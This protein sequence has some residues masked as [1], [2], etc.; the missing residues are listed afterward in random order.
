MLSTIKEFV[1]RHVVLTGMVVIL[2]CGFAYA[3]LTSHT[4]ALL[5]TLLLNLDAD[6]DGSIADETWLVT[7][8]DVGNADTSIVREGAGD[9][10]VEGNHIYRAGGTDVADGDV[11]DDITITNISQV[12][13]ISASAAE[14]NTPLDGASV[15]LTEFME[16]ETIGDTIIS[17]DQ[18]TGLGGATAA[19]MSLWNDADAPA[20]LVSLGVNAT[21]AE[22]DT[23]LDGASVTLTEFRELETIGDVTISA[24]QWAGLGGATT[25]GISL[26]TAANNAAIAG[27]L[28]GLDWTFTGTIDFTSA[29]ALSTGPLTIADEAIGM[30]TGIAAADYF[31]IGAYDA[32]TGPAY[33][34]LMRFVSGNTIYGY[35][36]DGVTNAIRWTEGGVMTFLGT[37]ALNLPSSDG[38]PATTAGQIRHDSTVANVETGALAWWDGDE[39]RYLVDLDVLPTDN[40]YVVS[41]DADADKWYMKLDAN[42]GGATALD[43]VSDPDAA[44]SIT[45]TDGETITFLSSSDNEIFLSIQ[46]DDEDLADVTY[47]L[48]LDWSAA[49]YDVGSADASNAIYLNMQDYT[50]TAYTFSG[51]QFS[52]Y[53]PIM[54]YEGNAAGSGYIA[55]TASQILGAMDGADDFC[56]GFYVAWT[57]ADHTNGFM[58]AFDAEDITG[59]AQATEIAYRVGTGWDYALYAESGGIYTVGTIEGA[60]L[61]DGTASINGGALTGLTT[62]LTVP[63]GGM[64]AATYTDGGI[65]TGNA[66]GIVNAMAVLADGEILVGDGATEPTA[67]QPAMSDFIPIGW[68][69]FDGTTDP[70]DLTE[71]DNIRYRDFAGETASEEGEFQWL[72]PGNLS[73]AVVKVRAIC[74]I[75]NATAPADTE[76]VSWAI[77]AVSAGS[78]DSHDAAV[79]AEANSEDTD[80]DDSAGAQWDIVFLPYVEVTPTNLAAGELVK[81]SVARDYDDADDTYVQDIGLIG[82]EIKYA[83]DLATQ[84]Y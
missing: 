5:D 72:A 61:T 55:Y 77:A 14:I 32:D 19:G 3:N 44:S 71:E 2:F 67:V 79:G 51:A 4:E 60:T 23:P 8:V 56:R 10:T 74:V 30:R 6:F 50:T 66:D 52:C 40:D 69:V 22:I 39:I 38:D 47:L 48:D 45:C 21:E 73:G 36:G 28:D 49:T 64:G 24:A 15:T 18:W 11:A 7:G 54:S 63:Q 12:G 17:A 75:T 59:D 62:P 81:F 13:D 76:G 58:H 42:D 78:D 43:D 65:L 68:F 37:S 57:S 29:T 53:R 1:K 35:L 26:I 34:G 31:E 83:I 9:I 27:I 20:M 33:N 70:G 16:L 84:T 46:D 41:Y 25:D 80:I 82:V